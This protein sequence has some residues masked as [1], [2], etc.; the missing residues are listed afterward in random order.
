MNSGLSYE[1]AVAQVRGE[2]D[3]YQQEHPVESMGLELTGA[4]ASPVSKGRLLTGGPLQKTFRAA[5]EGLI[6]GVGMGEGAEDS[7]AQGAEDAAQSAL[8]QGALGGAGKFLRKFSR[9]E[10]GPRLLQRDGEQI[11]ITEYLDPYSRM[12]QRY[13]DIKS[14]IPGR[15]MMARRYANLLGRTRQAVEDAAMGLDPA[16]RT[17]GDFTKAALSREGA[18]LRGKF[19]DASIPT[20]LRRTDDRLAREIMEGDPRS[21][22]SKLDDWYTDNMFADAK[23][24]AYQVDDVDAMTDRIW[25]RIKGDDVLAER[26]SKKFI[27]KELHKI[28]EDGEIPGELMVQLRSNIGMRAN[29]L[30]ERKG[31]GALD[32]AASFRLKSAIDEE[33]LPQMQAASSFIPGTPALKAEFLDQLESYKAYK[34]TQDLQTDAFDNFRPGAFDPKKAAKIAPKFVRRTGGGVLYDEAAEAAGRIEEPYRNFK[35][36]TKALE[37]MEDRSPNPRASGMQGMIQT[38]M[39][40]RLPA[41]MTA[42]AVGGAVGGPMGAVGGFAAPF[43]IG[44][45]RSA[46]RASDWGQRT[47]A[48][49][50]RVQRELNRGLYRARRSSKEKK[51]LAEQLRRGLVR[52]GAQG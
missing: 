7:V 39:L 20:T 2:I 28:E 27:S 49:Q 44:A 16:N 21:A 12:G 29:S 15:S 5:G 14:S 9:R 33:M 19:L 47:N 36:A 11:P 31:M 43:F 24:I 41:A 38:G 8:M 30:A 13:E 34:A 4:I 32:R 51:R 45:A 35:R 42:A 17:K 10:V 3:R 18:D 22:M 50:T 1:D 23:K 52:Y 37:E 25:K 26:L 40:G 6:A 46:T 48:G